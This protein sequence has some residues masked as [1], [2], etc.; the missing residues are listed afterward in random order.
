MS[1]YP[2]QPSAPP[3]IAYAQPVPSGTSGEQ[4]FVY[5]QAT[6][7]PTAPPPQSRSA[8]PP[9]FYSDQPPPYHHPGGYDPAYQ[10]TYATG[11]PP[12]QYQ[13]YQSQQ[14]YS[15][16]QQ[17]QQYEYPPPPPQVLQ[18]IIVTRVQEQPQDTRVIYIKREDELPEVN[19]AAY[20]ILT[21]LTGGSCFVCW[22]GA[23]FGCCP[24]LR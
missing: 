21:F 11:V 7:F 16:Q 5:A 1:G 9:Q 2:G 12:Q 8:A 14:Y 15:Q 19:H 4:G 6:N 20:C 23:V 17:Q 18:P 3:F 13:S 22:V 10:G 24:P